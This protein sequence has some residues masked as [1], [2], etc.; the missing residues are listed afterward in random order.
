MLIWSHESFLSKFAESFLGW[1]FKGSEFGD[2]YQSKWHP[3]WAESKGFSMNAVF[4]KKGRT[5]SPL[6]RIRKTA[7]PILV[8]LMISQEMTL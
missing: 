8:L 6:S 4:Q 1:I 2:P 3:R 7:F 5:K